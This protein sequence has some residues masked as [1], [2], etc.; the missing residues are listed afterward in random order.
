MNAIFGAFNAVG[1]GQANLARDAELA[2]QTAGEHLGKAVVGREAKTHRSGAVLDALVVAEGA[3]KVLDAAVDACVKARCEHVAVRLQKLLVGE[4]LLDA[5]H[6]ARAAIVGRFVR[7][8]FFRDGQALDGV[9]KQL[10]HAEVEVALKRDAAV[11]D[12]GEHALARVDRHV[13][14]GRPAFVDG[15]AAGEK[16]RH[17]LLRAQARKLDAGLFKGGTPDFAAFLRCAHGDRAQ[18]GHVRACRAAEKAV[19]EIGFVGIDRRD[20]A[21]VQKRNGVKIGILDDGK[22][23]DVNDGFGEVRPDIA[24][25]GLVD[26]AADHP[27]GESGPVFGGI[28]AIGGI[29]HI[30]RPLNCVD[31]LAA[32]NNSHAVSVKHNA[33]LY[34]A[35]SRSDSDGGGCGSLVSTVSH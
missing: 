20:A 4:D 35:A 21:R 28:A 19:V 14:V 8:V 5:K 18:R 9:G 34:P 24:V 27:G 13:G 3:F 10:V 30:G 2:F 25:V 15:R 33:S 12:D 17:E 16:R 11:F 29:G 1:A 32:L 23:Q 6:Q 26:N 31:S 7:I 22:R